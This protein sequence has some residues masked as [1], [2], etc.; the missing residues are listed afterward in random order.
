MKNKYNFTGDWISGFTQSDGSFVVSFLKQKKGLPIR[1]Q[2][3][4]NITQSI[5]ELEMFKALHNQLGIG[6]IYTNRKNVVFVVK[7]IDEIVD[8]ILP[9]FDKHPV[10]KRGWEILSLYYI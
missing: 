6:K 1:P 3:V 2:P 8:V 7:S 10:A 5:V 4:F 9:L